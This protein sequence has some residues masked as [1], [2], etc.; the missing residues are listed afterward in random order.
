MG[1]PPSHNNG[2]WLWAPPPVRNC[3]LGGGDEKRGPRH[4]CWPPLM[5]ISA[6]FTY[7]LVSVH[8]T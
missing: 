8:S 1:P 7:E 2:L 3:A 5:W 4:T 6:P